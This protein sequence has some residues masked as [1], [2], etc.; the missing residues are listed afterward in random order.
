MAYSISTF[1]NDNVTF[2]PCDYWII[3]KFESYILMATQVTQPVMK[4]NTSATAVEWQ[5][6]WDCGRVARV[7]RVPCGVRPAVRNPSIINSRK[8]KLTWRIPHLIHITRVLNPYFTIP[9][10]KEVLRWT[11]TLLIILQIVLLLV[12]CISNTFSVIRHHSILS[13]R[14]L[15]FSWYFEW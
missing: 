2:A 4:E 6:K 9:C 8:G 12:F 15:E 7:K 1:T 3:Y 10:I 14:C 11:K 13:V 5:I